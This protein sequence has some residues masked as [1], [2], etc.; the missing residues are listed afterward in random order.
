[1]SGRSWMRLVVAWAAALLLAGS[2]SAQDGPVRIVTDDDVNAVAYGLYCPVCPNERLDSCMTEACV[3]WREEIRAQLEAGRTPEEV[4]A[5]FVARY[6]ERAVGI[7]LD[8]TL[9]AFSVYTP[10]LFALAALV[11][12][13]MTLLRWRGSRRL[14]AGKPAR[15]S[16]EGDLQ[17]AAE[18]RDYRALLERDLRE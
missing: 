14:A 11:L 16:A 13:V 3:S 17:A 10:Y 9:R 12:A 6:G 15:S 2:V 7:P 18:D 8:P 1:M 5:D 4:V